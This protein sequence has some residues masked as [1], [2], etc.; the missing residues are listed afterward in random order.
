MVFPTIQYDDFPLWLLLFAR[1]P[2]PARYK[3]QDISMSD[4]AQDILRS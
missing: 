1:M 3:T 2:M 4:T